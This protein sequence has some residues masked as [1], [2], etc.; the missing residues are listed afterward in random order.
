M[1]KTII[2]SMLVI[3]YIFGFIIVSSIFADADKQFGVIP[4]PEPATLILLGSGL[5]GIATIGR[6]WFKR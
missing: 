6:N 4:I 1:K 2:V 5:L 3:I